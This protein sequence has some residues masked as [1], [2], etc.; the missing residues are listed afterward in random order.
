M[1]ILD[2][3][4][5]NAHW[6]AVLREGAIGTAVGLGVSAG[7]VAFIKRRQPLRYKSFNASLKTALWVMPTVTIGAFFAD[8]GSVNF[9][10]QMHQSDYLNQ[11]EAQK[12]EQWNKLSLADKI[13]TRVNENKY[14]I[15]I[16]A[17]ALSLWGSWHI[18]NKDKYMTTTQK[19]VQARVYAQAIT[20]VLLLGTVLLSMHEQ[21]LKKKQPPPVPEWK[22][23]LDEQE[24]HKREQQR[25]AQQQQKQ[26]EHE[27][28]KPSEGQAA[29]EKKTFEKKSE[30]KKELLK[31]TAKESL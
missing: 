14:K 4:E 7:L 2:D 25:L 27:S 13:F 28:A 17:W 15:I 8:E 29:H 16:S 19:A 18:V 22:K 3:E 30:E 26:K 24:S 21:E 31:E 6:N 10:R 11:Q 23:F 9:D 12:L 5:R 1:K 20:V